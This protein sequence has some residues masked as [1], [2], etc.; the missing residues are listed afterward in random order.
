MMKTP[1]ASDDT[2]SAEMAFEEADG[3]IPFS[4]TDWKSPPV[5]LF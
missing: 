3:S 1:D 2:S 5:W 4:S